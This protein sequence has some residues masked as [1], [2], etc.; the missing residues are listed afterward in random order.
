MAIFF[1]TI[2]GIVVNPVET[3]RDIAE[4]RPVIQGLIVI[5]VT[6]LLAGLARYLATGEEVVEYFSL[7]TPVGGLIIPGWAV[8]ILIANALIAG[9]FWLASH[10][11]GGNASF[12]ALLSGVCFIYSIFIVSSLIRLALTPFLGVEL[13]IPIGGLV[14][15]ATLAWLL[16]LHVIL[17]SEAN[18]FSKGRSVAAVIIPE[19]VIWG[20]FA[21]SIPVIMT[22]I[23]DRVG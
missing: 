12:T 19:L 5:I 9:L 10:V 3:A 21:G 23:W 4:R 15:L 13:I 22:D 6:G 7:Q 18:G 8:S 2:W 1:K 16:V 14:D 11:F 17:M 20:I